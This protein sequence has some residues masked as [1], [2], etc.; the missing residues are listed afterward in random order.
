MS[1]LC[2]GYYFFTAPPTSRE[3]LGL[4]LRKFTFRLEKRVA[5]GSREGSRVQGGIFRFLA[6]NRLTCIPF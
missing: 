3:S 5:H 1:I 6:S 2:L 4:R